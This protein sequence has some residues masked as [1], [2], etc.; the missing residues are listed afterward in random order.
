MTLAKWVG[1]EMEGGDPMTSC[2]LHASDTL[3]NVFRL[4][5][6]HLP[7]GWSDG[8]YKGTLHNQLSQ[9]S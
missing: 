1:T 7:S 3:V 6:L 9:L 2:T 5:T 8:M 4:T